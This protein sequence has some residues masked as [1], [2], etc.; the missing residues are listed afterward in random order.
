MGWSLL[1]EEEEVEER[2]RDVE[3]KVSDA[4]E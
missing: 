4:K 1:E 3:L 2:D